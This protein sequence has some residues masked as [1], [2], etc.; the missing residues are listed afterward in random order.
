MLKLKCREFDIVFRMDW[1]SKH[2]DVMDV[3][4]KS[5]TLQSSYDWV[6][7]MGYRKYPLNKVVSAALVDRKIRQG[8]EAFLAHVVDIENLRS[9][10][11]FI[12]MVGEFFMYLRR[13]YS[14]YLQ[15]VK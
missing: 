10:G 5:I 4:A 2:E 12:P 6:T 9:D 15:N 11:R 13:S 8:C 3:K 14:N 1:L 7:F